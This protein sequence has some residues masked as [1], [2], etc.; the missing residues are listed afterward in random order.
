MKNVYFDD[1]FWTKEK[2]NKSIVLPEKKRCFFKF[3]KKKKYVI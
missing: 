3:V 1:Y 2:L